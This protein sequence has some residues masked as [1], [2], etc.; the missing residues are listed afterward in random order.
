MVR[1]I[2][3]LSLTSTACGRESANPHEG[4]CAGSRDGRNAVGVGVVQAKLVCQDGGIGPYLAPEV[5]R[6]GTD[7]TAPFR[8]GEKERKA[9]V[10][11]KPHR[12]YRDVV[13]ATKRGWEDESL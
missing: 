8:R 2:H 10:R 12:R 1:M 11:R 13:E 3:P 5:A 6:C 7:R 4:K 9:D